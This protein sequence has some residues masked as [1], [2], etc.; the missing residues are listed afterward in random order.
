MSMQESFKEAK[1]YPVEEQKIDSAQSKEE[2]TK[3]AQGMPW[4]TCQRI[5]KKYMDLDSSG[6]VYSLFGPWRGKKSFGSHIVYTNNNIVYDPINRF[7]GS[8]EDYLKKFPI[9]TKQDNV[10]NM[11]K[12]TRKTKE[13]FEKVQSMN[14]WKD[15][16]EEYEKK[17]QKLI[18]WIEKINSYALIPIKT[19]NYDWFSKHVS[20]YQTDLIWSF[21]SHDRSALKHFEEDYRID[22]SETIVFVDTRFLLSRKGNEYGDWKMDPVKD[23]LKQNIPFSSFPIYIMSDGE[24]GEGNHRIKALSELGYKAIPV[25]IMWK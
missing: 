17:K 21:L 25:K 19:D 7:E 4:G 16:P 10:T 9:I 23:L 22:P 3:I 18:Q 6:Q 15:S 12:K 13:S 5:A 8:L 1:S 20:Q 2:L 14:Q 24:V 11:Y